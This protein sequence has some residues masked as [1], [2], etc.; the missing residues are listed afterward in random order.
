M[1]R[2]SKVESEVVQKIRVAERTVEN[3]AIDKDDCCVIQGATSV[4]YSSTGTMLMHMLHAGYGGR[5]NLFHPV[6][7]LKTLYPASLLLYAI[8]ITHQVSPVGSA[9]ANATC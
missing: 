7:L 6:M 2:V 5:P 9:S 3:P 8:R 4:R 1:E